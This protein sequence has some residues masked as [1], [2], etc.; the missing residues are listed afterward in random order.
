MQNTETEINELVR[1]L[2]VL[3]FQWRKQHSKNLFEAAQTIVI[4]YHSVFARLWELGWNGE[5]LLPDEELPTQL[6][7]DYFID[8]WREKS[9][10]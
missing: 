8:Y 9:E 4:E 7:P 6:M 3:A 10:R 5:D 2:A 1:R